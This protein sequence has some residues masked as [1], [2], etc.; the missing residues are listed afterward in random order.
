[1]PSINYPSTTTAGHPLDQ[2]PLHNNSWSSP[3]INYPST[4]TAGHPLNS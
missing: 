3:L 2:L 1:M 4:T